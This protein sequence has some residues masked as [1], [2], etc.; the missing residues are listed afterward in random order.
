MQFGRRSVTADTRVAYVDKHRKTISPS[1]KG[2]NTMKPTGS[3]GSM[4]ELDPR[5]ARIL[6]FDHTTR[7]DI[8]RLA[9]LLVDGQ[10]PRWIASWEQ[11][12]PRNSPTLTRGHGRTL[13]ISLYDDKHESHRSC[14]KLCC[15]ARGFSEAAGKLKFRPFLPEW[16]KDIQQFSL[17]AKVKRSVEDA[18]CEMIQRVLAERLSKYRTDWLG[19]Q[20]LQAWIEREGNTT[21]VLRLRVRADENVEY[22]T[23]DLDSSDESTNSN[24]EARPSNGC[25]ACLFGMPLK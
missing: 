13:Y 21:V 24:G 9:E 19:Q 15:R 22:D 11:S 5:V 16:E 18:L 6:S 3:C 1:R 4:G 17:H 23:E 2:E 14:K 25:L 8:Y 7:K 12:G 10:L 20:G